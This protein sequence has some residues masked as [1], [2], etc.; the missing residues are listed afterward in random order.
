MRFTRSLILVLFI[1]SAGCAKH[2]PP[3]FESGLELVSRIE[4]P[5]T[6]GVGGVFHVH[7]L[8]DSTVLFT[9]F[10]LRGIFLY[11][12]GDPLVREVGSK[13]GGPGE[14]RMPVF[15]DVVAD[16]I[17]FSDMGSASIQAIT[18]NGEYVTTLSHPYGGARRFVVLA[19][20]L[21]IAPM[22][23]PLAAA[24][25]LHGPSKGMLSA[26]GEQSSA[27]HRAAILSDGGGIVSD[28]TNLFV[29]GTLEPAIYVVDGATGE[30]ARK[31]PPEWGSMNPP[32]MFT[33][34]E[35]PRDFTSLS[36]VVQ[37][38]RLG[39]VRTGDDEP[40][41]F[42]SLTRGEAHAIHILD[43]DGHVIQEIESGSKLL[44]GAHDKY[45]ILMDSKSD[46]S[47]FELYVYR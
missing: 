17:Y 4:V 14:Y 19:D 1:G 39:L 9:D 29:V 11:R 35:S 28:G 34:V 10:G 5:A 31:Q 26:Y 27:Y 45:V 22:Q 36:D 30:V 41:L 3:S 47:A 2:A 46:P 16:T 20:S 23:G 7:A 32:A 33:N 13:G 38:R 6:S 8:N 37:F 18:L 40:R 42:V 24:A 21:I 15:F 12:K 25:R 43:L 44:M